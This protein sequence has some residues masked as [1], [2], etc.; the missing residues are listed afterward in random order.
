MYANNA[1]L[2][3]TGGSFFLNISAQR[4]SQLFPDPT[5]KLLHFCNT[6]FTS[7]FLSVERVSINSV[8]STVMID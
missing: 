1:T 3:A 7:F 5:E 4:C 8:T 6:L 2:I